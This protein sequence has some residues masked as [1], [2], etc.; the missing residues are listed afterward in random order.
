MPELPTLRERTKI[1]I[2]I[3]HSGQRGYYWFLVSTLALLLFVGCSSAQSPSIPAATELATQLASTPQAQIGT[4]KLEF[5]ANGEDFIRQGFISKDGWSITFDHMYVTLADMTAYQA[6]PPYDAESGGEIVAKSSISLD[7][8]Y[9]VDLAAGD[10]D[11]EPLLIGQADAPTGRYNA[12]AWKL[13]RAVDGP[14]SGAVIMMQGT[15]QK[16]KQTIPFTISLDVESSYTCGDY[17]GDERKGILKTGETTDVEAT[18]HFDH[19]FGDGSMPP[20]DSVNTDAVGFAPLAAL[21]TDGVLDVGMATLQ[22]KLLPDVY[23]NVTHTHL[24]HVGEGHC[25]NTGGE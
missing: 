25:H 14:S 21:A 22:E 23:D 5:R 6:D 12:L 20:D 3:V 18:F 8:P 7:K 24:A 11:A 1:L 19:F 9:T 2:N 13:V 17:V 10:E 4:G 16:E 15:A